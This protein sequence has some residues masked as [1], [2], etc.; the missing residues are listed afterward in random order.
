MRT[1]YPKR[2]GWNPVEPLWEGHTEYRESGKWPEDN[3][4]SRA[5]ISSRL[6]DLED[7]IAV[8]DWLRENVSARGIDDQD[9]G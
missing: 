3:G 6:N 4:Q 9:L 7:S 2:A 1:T 8:P 5:E